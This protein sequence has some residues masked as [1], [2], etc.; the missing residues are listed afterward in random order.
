MGLAPHLSL[1]QL[2]LV[3]VAAGYIAFDD[4][5]AHWFKKS[6]KPPEINSSYLTNSYIV[7]TLT[8]KS[9]QKFCS[10]RGTLSNKLLLVKV[11]AGYIAFDDGSAHWIKDG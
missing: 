11:A 1:P 9:G 6:K 5:S 3:K 4:G 7:F 2:L 8:L 10:K